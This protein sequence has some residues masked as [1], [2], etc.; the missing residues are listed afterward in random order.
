MSVE[1]DTG[2]KQFQP[3]IDLHPL[4]S[5]PG[6]RPCRDASLA[7]AWITI[8]TSQSRVTNRTIVS[9]RTLSDIVSFLAEACPAA[10]GAFLTQKAHPR[11][12]I[13]TH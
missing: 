11:K 12:D 5:D 4:H 10:A 7:T 8:E 9:H 6:P 13:T 1:A 3:V 2:P